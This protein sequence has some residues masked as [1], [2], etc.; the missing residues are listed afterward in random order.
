MPSR[1]HTSAPK[2]DGRPGSLERYFRDLKHLS[3]S[4]SITEARK[5]IDF[6]TYYLTNEEAE[7]WESLDTYKGADF[8]AFKTEVF[9]LYPGA[10]KDERYLVADLDKLVREYERTEEVTTDNLGEFHR[11]YIRIS[12]YLKGKKRLSD[13]EAKRCFL[14]G[15]PGGFRDRVLT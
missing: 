12:S 2:F 11:A 10:T 4:A 13:V 1:N 14:K 7:L 3:N 9:G 15:L 5:L 6:A 8:E